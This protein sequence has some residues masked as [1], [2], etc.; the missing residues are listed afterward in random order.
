[1]AGIDG[2]SHLALGL[3][4]RAA[5]AFDAIRG[6]SETVYLRNH[7]YYTVQLAEATRRQGDLA[8]AADVAS[9]VLPT[10]T[11]MQS[12]RTTQLV[13]KLR[14]DLCSVSPAPRAVR[15][16]VDAYDQAVAP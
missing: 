15:R 10:I 5:A 11:K 8:G 14:S 9:A 3:P 13:A 4:S 1:V 6:S 7:A 16:F 12:R 2:L